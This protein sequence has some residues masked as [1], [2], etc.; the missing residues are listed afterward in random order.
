MHGESKRA[1]VAAFLA[2]LG[3]AVAKFVGFLFTGAT[4]MMAEAI[5]SVADTSNQALLLLGGRL[6]RR[7][8]TPDHPFGYGRERFFWAFIVALVIFSL[9]ALFALYEGISKIRH[10]HE[11]ESPAWAIGILVV[12]ACLEGLSFRTAI[13]E[14]NKL[15][16]DRSWTSFVLHAKV[17]ELPVVLLEDFGALLGLLFALT[18]VTLALVTGDSRFDA[19]GSVAIGLLLG[20]IAVVLAMEM[21]SLLIGEA[22]YPEVRKAIADAVL[23]HPLTRRII[24]MRT[25]HLGPEELLV[26]IKVELDHTLDF[27]GVSK[28]IDSIEERLR[29][30]CPIARVVYI[31]PD[32]YRGEISGDSAS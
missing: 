25:E 3:I 1:I 12:A 7:R 15:R 30:A 18:G 31:E 5:H 22:A 19:L 6:A 9:G 14:S 29:A 27:E 8:A 21:K 4:S 20:V 32:V 10:P 26:G 16:G 13:K 23:A 17:P 28:A 2:N 24:H 11:L